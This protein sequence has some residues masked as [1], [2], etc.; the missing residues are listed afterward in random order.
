M[1]LR[2]SPFAWL[3][4]LA[5]APG[6]AAADSP[7]VVKDFR[8]P[9]KSLDPMVPPLGLKMYRDLG[10]VVDENML[11]RETKVAPSGKVMT[12]GGPW[13]SPLFDQGNEV[14]FTLG[15]AESPR[16]IWCSHSKDRG[17]T[18]SEPRFVAAL[19]DAT[20]GAAIHGVEL[21]KVRGKAL[22]IRL[23]N[24]LGRKFDVQLK[25][26]DLRR[27][28]TAGDL[29]NAP[30]G[31]FVLASV[32]PENSDPDRLADAVCIGRDL[33]FDASH[34]PASYKVTAPL[35]LVVHEAM[36]G[37]L[38]HRAQS[39]EGSL[40]ETRAVVTPGGDY[41]VMIPDGNHANSP[42]D[43]ANRLVGYRSSDQGKTWAGP[44]S[45]FGDEAKHHAALALVPKDEKRIYVFETQRGAVAQAVKRDRVF[46]FRSSDDDGR[47]WSA[48]ELLHLGG[49]SW[50]GGVGVIQMT[51]TTAGTWMVGF[52]HSRMLRG[53]LDHGQREWSE[54]KPLGKPELN[55]PEAIF[56]LDELR[57]LGLKGLNVLAMGRTCEGHLWEIRS[58]DDGRSWSGARPTSLVQPDAPPMTFY[59]SDKKTL[60]ALHHNRAVLRS[61]HEPNH[62]DWLA[63]PTPTAEQVVLGNRFPHSLQDWVSRAEV[64][65]SLSKDEGQTWGEP[66]F[67]FANAL[68][69][70]LDGANPNYQCSYVDL[71]TDRGFVHL[72]I[73]H[74][75]QRVVHL[76]F[77][78]SQLDAFLTRGELQRSLANSTPPQP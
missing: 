59:L 63:M 27:L 31:R 38:L 61:I 37:Q 67:L 42:R 6:L 35:G 24:G 57:V 14:K 72:I 21:A 15:G 65:F 4:A 25:E 58:A 5:L 16:T 62:S 64:W 77:P 19:V 36:E 68:A 33:L 53:A 26:N 34:P 40:F 18:W 7:S 75:W 3:V 50:F 69:E 44:F 12:D 10:L 73:P 43:D 28:A 47:H 48:P 8:I 56:H 46:G 13:V 55:T 70:T 39:K 29:R 78:E 30:A 9:G 32:P 66:R 17:Q 76:S 51:E 41:L 71:F 49:K 2:S 20:E 11:A 45:V 22:S 74:R 52:H 54:V 23:G 1:M 60:I